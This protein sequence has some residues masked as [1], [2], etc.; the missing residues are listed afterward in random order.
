MG[1]VETSR[2]SIDTSCDGDRWI[3]CGYRTDE[4]TFNC[5]ERSNMSFKIIIN[6]NGYDERILTPNNRIKR[7]AL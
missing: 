3:T 2:L 1:A 7:K 6:S 5:V 4:I